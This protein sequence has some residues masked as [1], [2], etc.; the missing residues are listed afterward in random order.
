MKGG[1][2][3]L[4]RYY[5]LIANNYDLTCVLCAEQGGVPNRALERVLGEPVVRKMNLGGGL[6]LDFI[7]DKPSGHR[8]HLSQT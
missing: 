4:H 8:C 2:T 3:E 5:V 1:D 7:P 6:G